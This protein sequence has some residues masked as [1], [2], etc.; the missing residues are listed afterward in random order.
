MQVHSPA[1]ALTSRATHAHP[2]SPRSI[3]FCAIWDCVSPSSFVAMCSAARGGVLLSYCQS[4]P[5]QSSR[6]ALRGTPGSTSPQPEP[7]LTGLPR[8]Q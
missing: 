6:G 7:N 2:T 8:C 1:S 4:S 3:G 5:V